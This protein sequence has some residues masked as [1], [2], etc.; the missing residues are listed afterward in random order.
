MHPDDKTKKKS[1]P[2]TAQEAPSES[3]DAIF[4]SIPFNSKHFMIVSF[5]IWELRI[6]TEYLLLLLLLLLRIHEHLYLHTT[7]FDHFSN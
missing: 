4:H 2:Y 5:Y 7:F 3:T 1:N 6:S